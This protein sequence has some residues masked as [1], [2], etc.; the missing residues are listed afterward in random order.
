MKP[1]NSYNELD[2]SSYSDS[3]LLNILNLNS[4][5]DRELEA[6]IIQM[7]Q[8]YSTKESETSIKYQNFYRDIYK[9]F[10]DV[11]SDSDGEEGFED[12]A[13]SNS[14]DSEDG[15]VVEGLE[16]MNATPATN[17][18]PPS[19]ENRIQDNVALTRPLDYSKDQLNPLLKQVIKRTVS[20]DSQF[21]NREFYKLPTNFAFNLSEPL[22]DVV[23]LRLYSIQI[24][25]TWFT[26]SNNYGGNIIYIKGNS[27]GIDNDN[28][29]LSIG[30]PPGNYTQTDIITG[31][32]GSIDALMK[33]R[34]DISFGNGN[35]FSYNAS[36]VFTTANI[37]INNTFNEL[38][39]KLTFANVGY[40]TI[41][42]DRYGSVSGNVTAKL[43]AFLG[44]NNAEYDI[45]RI[46][47]TRNI[48]T[49]PLD[50][51]QTI[52]SI[53]GSNN[54]IRIVQYKYTDINTGN[55][56]TPGNIV[57]EFQV[58]IPQGVYTESALY[59]QINNSI[60][61][62]PYLDTSISKLNK[63]IIPDI[64]MANYGFAYY[65][66]VIQ[67]L[68][69]TSKFVSGDKTVKTAV[70]LP[71]DANI[72]VGTSSLFR[73]DL[74]INELNL[75]RA[76]TNSKQNDFYANTDQYFILRCI[77]PGYTNSSGNIA[78]YASLPYNNTNL[79]IFKNDIKVALTYSN[80]ITLNNF[81][82][83]INNAILATNNVS[84]G[85]NQNS[86]LGF[87][88]M[89]TTN[90][91][92][93]S[94][95]TF[96]L[97]LDVNNI[98]NNQSYKVAF[99]TEMLGGSFSSFADVSLN[100]YSGTNTNTNISTFISNFVD[101][102]N[103]GIGTSPS[104]PAKIL[105][106]YPQPTANNAND[107]SW[108]IFLY[109][110]A[111][112]D[113][114]AT[115]IQSAI[116][117]F[118]FNGSYPM[119]NTTVSYNAN[120]STFAVNLSIN[121]VL[122]QNNYV[123]TFYDGAGNANWE[124]VYLYSNYDYPISSNTNITDISGYQP[125]ESQNFI[126]LE[127]T[128]FTLSSIYDA[129]AEENNITIDISANTYTRV[130]LLDT[131]NTKLS[132]NPLTSGSYMYVYFDPVL[133]KEFIYFKVN[134]AKVY[135]AKDYRLVYYDLVSFVK[136][137]VGTT[138]V[139]NASWDSTLGWTLG[140]RNTEY[141]LSQ[142]VSSTG[143]TSVVVSESSLD[144]FPYKYFYIIL[145][146]YNQSR[147]NDGLITLSMAENVIAQPSYAPVQSFVC[148]E[149]G[150]KVFIGSD[151]KPLTSNQI[152]AA[153]QIYADSR[154]KQ[155]GYS[156]TPFLKDVF[157]II[158]IKPG[159]AG[160]NYV[161]FGGTLQNQERLYF[162]PVNIFRMSIKLID[163][164]GD[165]VDLNNNEWSFSFICEQLYRSDA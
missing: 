123:L 20:I 82:N 155:S 102:T 114:T 107:I 72:W 90:V 130:T 86:T 14:E 154:A 10:F 144:I 81:L 58:I 3:E 119:R 52:H 88:N 46:Y 112:G 149:S 18:Q 163:D 94:T 117:S 12:D 165:V 141:D 160:S 164:R 124:Q 44:F 93:D 30:I 24:P 38:G 143:G 133:S 27:P 62:N 85:L 23:A 106:I 147:L 73:F 134:I 34:L 25:Y 59:N 21:R 131:I 87:F 104:N 9:R 156:S 105:T 108:N 153:N 84:K 78:Q 56:Y 80:K 11:E 115:N 136:C 113:Q 7:I 116:T 22:R 36:T 79:H 101:I 28:Y 15:N 132:E 122:T 31:I 89:S 42:D 157:G 65:E 1:Y 40:T 33:Q 121:N 35:F 68:R 60:Q 76:E 2:V 6:R 92:V 66:L 98:F 19:N 161:E 111:Q 63:V 120:D 4:P 51:I 16:N 109:S 64:S 135:T 150:N 57:S 71:N 47:S 83:N 158:P 142:Y 91:Y 17:T 29:N 26:V 137:Y 145:D 110:S 96:H 69:N 140:F 100:V 41:D 48:S 37:Y 32:N 5:T 75:I 148:D 50:T 53:D 70:I 55:Y 49:A 67:L 128:S 146:D 129:I 126:L 54:T 159:P 8:R 77:Q 139:R 152:Y 151:S 125:A 97:V 43:N 74:S 99:N 162:G 39:Y 138:S 45:N 61:S 118:F 95:N 13:Q 103:F 127:D